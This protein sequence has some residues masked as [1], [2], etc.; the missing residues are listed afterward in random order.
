VGCAPQAPPAT[1]D[2]NDPDLIKVAFA[3][4]PAKNEWESA[5][6]RS[7][8]NTFTA[9]DGFL[10]LQECHAAFNPLAP[11]AVQCF[12]D[13]GM[14]YLL[15]PTM[16]A[17]HE[18]FIAALRVAND[19]GIPVIIVG[20]DYDLIDEDLYIA[21]IASDYYRQG[22]LATLWLSG[23]LRARERHNEDMH[24][25]FIGGDFLTHFPGTNRSMRAYAL[26]NPTWPNDNRNILE[27]VEGFD[28]MPL[29]EEEMSYFIETYPEVNAVYIE[30]GMTALGAVDAIKAAG[31]IPGE[32]IIVMTFGGDHWALRSIIQRG[33]TMAVAVN[34]MYGPKAREII[35]KLERGETVEKVYYLQ[36]KVIDLDAVADMLP[37]TAFG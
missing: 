18:D 19:A 14:Q 4:I 21:A 33:L 20:S 9:A 24:I 11:D 22:R 12:I 36:D 2:N 3:R 35:E 27:S 17:R 8:D 5:F 16:F 10:L 26:L 34:P 6:N 29:G 13:Q 23:Y 30:C 28:S 7:F 15:A 37:A 25:A 31:K 32:D 1:D